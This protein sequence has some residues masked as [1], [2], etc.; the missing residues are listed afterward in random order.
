[1]RNY[2]EDKISSIPK[3]Y[4]SQITGKVLDIGCNEC[5]LP[6]KININ[7]KNY[8]GL[9]I[10]EYALLIAEKKGFKVKKLDLNNDEIPISRNSIDSFICLDVLEHLQDPKNAIKKIKEVLKFQAK[11][12]ISLPNDLN[13]SNLMKVLIL[14]RPLL[15]REKMWDP[16]S[17][18][19]FPSISESEKL[20][21][22]NF[23]ILSISYRSSEFTVPFLPKKLKEILASLFPRYF[24]KNIIF[25]VENEN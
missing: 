16:H 18:L 23:K 3:N 15:I 21:S 22:Q 6:E 25:L 14:G 9:D 17:H 13:L 24:A 4:F 11:G 1:M 20:I 8:L 5:I 19:H 12:I 7:K 10:D 2:S